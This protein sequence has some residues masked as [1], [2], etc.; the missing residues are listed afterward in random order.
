MIITLIGLGLILLAIVGFVIRKIIKMQYYVSGIIYAVSFVLIIIGCI[1]S[2]ICIPFIICN[3]T[4]ADKN[5]YDDKLE[6]DS[7][8]M[9][10]EYISSDYED[11][12]K[13][14]VIQN[15]YNWNKKVYNAKYWSSNPWTSWFWNKRMVDSLE[16]I[17]ID[18][19]DLK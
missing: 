2:I 6:H 10:V 18:M 17:D 9:Q 15:V 8:V 14:S 5:I 4:I 12:S 3:N 7:I 16:Y 11:V 1:R 13:S 19:E